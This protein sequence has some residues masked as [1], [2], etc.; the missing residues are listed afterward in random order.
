MLAELLIGLSLWT[1]IS[2]VTAI[3]LGRLLQ[4]GKIPQVRP[5]RHSQQN[6]LSDVA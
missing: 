6:S 5:D 4:L 2:V 3:A 1:A